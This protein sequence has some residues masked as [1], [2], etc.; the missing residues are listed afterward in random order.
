MLKALWKSALE[1][2]SLKVVEVA[3]SAVT[4]AADEIAIRVLGPASCERDNYA[5]SST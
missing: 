3:S 5:L 1:T 4:C 2:W